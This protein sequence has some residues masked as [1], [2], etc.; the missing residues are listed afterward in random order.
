MTTMNRAMN[1]SVATGGDIFG[2]A[3]ERQAAR[4]VK[5]WAPGIAGGAAGVAGQGPRRR[6]AGY[7]LVSS[8]P[9]VVKRAATLEPVKAP[10]PQPATAKAT[11]STAKT[12][13][14]TKST[15]TAKPMQ[16]PTPAKPTPKPKRAHDLLALA[17]REAAETGAKV[18]E[19]LRDMAAKDP[20]AYRM[21]L[22]R[23]R[24]AGTAR[25]AR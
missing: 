6:R 24:Q 3:I 17:R 21:W 23:E 1:L 13:T 7:T 2:A 14:A 12:I 4:A 25:K 11:P 9:P 5:T 15:A 19:I 8:R 20:V 22:E 16:A 18:T 10:T